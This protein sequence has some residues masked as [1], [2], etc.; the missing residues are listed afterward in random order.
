MC[1]T[2]PHAVIVAPTSNHSF[3]RGGLF[4]TFAAKHFELGVDGTV[5]YKLLSTAK[6]TDDSSKGLGVDIC[7]NDT[8]RDLFRMVVPVAEHGSYVMYAYLRGGLDVQPGDLEMNI[9]HGSQSSLVFQIIEVLAYNETHQGTEFV[10]STSGT[11][12]RCIP[13]RFLDHYEIHELA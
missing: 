3:S 5:C 11:T 7:G 13:S 8:Q 2:G 6:F 10:F 4:F 9:V 12:D 1:R